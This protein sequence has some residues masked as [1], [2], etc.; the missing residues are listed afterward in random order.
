QPTTW[1]SSTPALAPTPTYSSRTASSACRVAGRAGPGQHHLDG[2]LAALAPD[3]HCIRRELVG[4]LQHP[5][6]EPAP[7]RVGDGPEPDVEEVGS[8][9]RLWQHGDHDVLGAGEGPHHRH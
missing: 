2:P 6:P 5:I 4:H 3:H 7:D 9:S 8:P 1:W